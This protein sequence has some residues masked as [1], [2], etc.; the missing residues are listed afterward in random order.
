MGM[1]YADLKVPKV[2]CCGSE[3]LAEGTLDFLEAASL[4]RKKIRAGL[5]LADDNLADE[6][7]SFLSHFLQSV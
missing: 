5:P 4:H 2:F 3:S 6:F 7:Y 1:T